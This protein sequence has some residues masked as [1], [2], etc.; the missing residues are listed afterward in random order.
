MG[1]NTQ[2]EKLRIV[3]PVSEGDNQCGRAAKFFNSSSPIH[4]IVQLRTLEMKWKLQPEQWCDGRLIDAAAAQETC[5]SLKENSMIKPIIMLLKLYYN[6][7]AGFTWQYYFIKDKKK[8]NP[9]R[10][11]Y[12]LAEQQCGS[13]HYDCSA[14][15]EKMF[16]F[17]T[18]LVYDVIP[19]WQQPYTLVNVQAN[20]MHQWVSWSHS[21]IIA[22][23]SYLFTK[24][25]FSLKH[26]T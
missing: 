5:Q 16:N 1:I 3:S 23:Y 11:I 14:W 21:L 17:L 12:S 8:K 7:S 25:N 10:N 20:K 24:E 13:D 18:K 19:T 9:L 15:K 22:D 2:T 4:Y 26:L 6:N